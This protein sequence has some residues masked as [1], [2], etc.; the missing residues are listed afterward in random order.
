[1]TLVTTESG[2]AMLRGTYGGSRGEVALLAGSSDREVTPVGAGACGIASTGHWKLDF[3]QHHWLEL[4]LR[5]GGR[6]FELAIQSNGQWE[7]S[8]QL[9][10]ASIPHTLTDAPAGD[11]DVSGRASEGGGRG[12]YA[13]LGVDADADDDEIRTA[14]RNLVKEVHPDRPGGDEEEFKRVSRAYSLV[15]EAESRARYD[16]FG[17]E[18]DADDDDGLD[19]LGEWRSVKVPFTA[20]RD[21]S[22]YKRAEAIDVVYILLAG[23]RPGPFALEVGEIK[24]GRCEKGQLDGAGQT[25]HISCE[26]GHCECGFYNG[27]RVD[28]FDGP[29]QKDANGRVDASRLKW[30]YAEH[31]FEPGESNW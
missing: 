1:V 25:G 16:Q 14:Y 6:D 4:K 11:A 15:G 26:M 27:M 29:L 28:A 10:R 30:G 18:D 9:W 20:F 12:A 24:A 8:A 23:E 31:H 7:G 22:L 2:T 21:R 17:A 19:D 3:A 13:I 5:T